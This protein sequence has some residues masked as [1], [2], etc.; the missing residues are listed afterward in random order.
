[1]FRGQVKERQGD[2]SGAAGDYRK[3]LDLNPNLVNAHY[4]LAMIEGRLGHREQAALHRKRWDRLREARAQLR[5]ASAEYRTALD[6][7]AAASPEPSAIADLRAAT[8]RLASVCE[9]L[10]WARAV[11]ACN[12]IVAGL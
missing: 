12:Q 2:P 11:Q 3:A 7:A 6:A 5:Q 9:N 1:M 8:R 4:R 10:G